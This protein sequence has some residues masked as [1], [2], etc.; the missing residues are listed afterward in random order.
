LLYFYLSGLEKGR[1]V[2]FF[3]HLLLVQRGDFVNKSFEIVFVAL[4]LGYPPPQELAHVISEVPF[5]EASSCKLLFE[6]SPA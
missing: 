4:A 2:S 5:R 6:R 1:V 3:L